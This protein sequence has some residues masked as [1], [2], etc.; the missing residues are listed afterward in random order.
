M[1]ITF[2]LVFLTLIANADWKET[3][4]SNVT[5]NQYFLSIPPAYIQMSS[6]ND[7]VKLFLFSETE[8]T[9]QI[10]NNDGI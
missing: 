4:P 6:P 7:Y 8:Q 10:K 3:K 1:K 5:G 2:L 9:I